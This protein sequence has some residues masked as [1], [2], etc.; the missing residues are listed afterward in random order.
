MGPHP[1]DLSPATQAFIRTSPCLFNDPN[2]SASKVQ[3]VQCFAGQVDFKGRCVECTKPQTSTDG[4]IS[5]DRC[6]SGS[7]TVTEPSLISGDQ[8]HCKSC[9]GEIIHYTR[10][11]TDRRPEA[12]ECRTGGNWLPIPRGNHWM[13]L[14][15]KNPEY[16]REVKVCP[17]ENCR[18]PS[19]SDAERCL[20]SVAALQGSVTTID[21]VCVCWRTQNGGKPLLTYGCSTPI[22]S[23]CREPTT[24]ATT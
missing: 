24:R 17:G 20:R 4:A 1:G 6:V 21:Q 7:Y 18:A 15:S 5:C 9:G 12:E 2:T 8:A 14:D 19:D 3:Q 16:V 11:N 13:L 23:I 10:S 22:R